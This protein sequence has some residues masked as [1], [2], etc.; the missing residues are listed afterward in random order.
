MNYILNDLPNSI[1]I[2]L[3][4]DKEQDTLKTPMWV[5]SWREAE[6]YINA[7]LLRLEGYKKRLGDTEWC[8]EVASIM[9]LYKLIDK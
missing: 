5:L 6:R 2:L 9:R 1:A 3:Y 7:L 8:E 4:Y